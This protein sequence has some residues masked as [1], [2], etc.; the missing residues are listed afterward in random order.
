[1]RLNEQLLRSIIRDMILTEAP[2]VGDGIYR[3]EVSP[4][5]NEERG[6]PR[7]IYPSIAYNQS[8]DPAWI[9]EARVLMRNTTENW[10]IVSLS[11]SDYFDEGPTGTIPIETPGFNKWIRA[12]NIPKGTR[13]IVIGSGNYPGDYENVA[14]AIGHDIFGHTLS[15][16]SPDID[17]G[18]GTSGSGP[19]INMIHSHLPEFARLSTDDTDRLPDIYAAIFLKIVSREYFDEM[20]NSIESD[21]FRELVINVLDEMFEGVDSWISSI[22]VDKPYVIIP[23]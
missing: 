1:M 12:Q 7:N 9:D 2:L 11:R 14:W 17:F 13:I 5:E 10:A 4:G 16:H 8:T 18:S 6:M 20:V 19:S 22:P 23:W 21:K 15:G 3:Y